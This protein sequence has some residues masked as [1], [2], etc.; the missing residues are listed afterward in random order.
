MRAVSFGMLAGW[1]CTAPV[2]GQATSLPQQ[3][4]VA[5]RNGAPPVEQ[6]TT[7]D[8]RRAELERIDNRWQ[9]RAGEISLKDFGNHEK[10]AREA[11]HLIRELKLTQHGAVGAPL[12]VME[13]WLSDGHAPEGLISGLQT[14]A[15]DPQLLRVEQI[16]GQ[17]CLRDARQVLFA[18]GSHQAEAQRALE[19]IRYH[20]FS[21]VGYLGHPV[22]LMMYFLTGPA[23]KGHS[24]ASTPEPMTSRT[25][26]PNASRPQRNSLEDQHPSLARSSGVPSNGSVPPDVPSVGRQL[27]VPSSV[28]PVVAAQ[29]ERVQFDWRQ[30]QVRNEDQSWKLVYGPYTL[31]DFGPNLQDARQAQ[32]TVQFYRFTEQCRV[33]GSSSYLTYYLVNGQA[34]RGIRFGTESVSFHPDMLKVQKLGN[35]FGIADGQQVVLTFGAREEGAHQVFQAI[36]RHK[37]D[38]LCHIGNPATGGMTFF[39]RAR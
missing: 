25:R 7:F 4:P 37:F 23:G 3:M 36:H 10:E 1:L 5:I 8:H 12:P 38:H 27:S 18:F 9:L 2:L 26:I 32:A 11:L 17:W 39:A 15:I 29:G 34:P 28:L 22:P 24:M 6:L 20:G 30:V 35:E 16:Q 14:T 19:I 21:Q 31:A 13:Y 33:G